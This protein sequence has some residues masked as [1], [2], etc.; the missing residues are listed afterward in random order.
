M[1]FGTEVI[2][3]NDFVRLTLEEDEV[4][5]N[6]SLEMEFFRI[7]T[8]YRL[9]NNQIQFTGDL[10]VRKYEG[11][12]IIKELGMSEDDER[13]QRMLTIGS[14]KYI[15]KNFSQEE[16]TVDMEDL[17]GRFYIDWEELTEPMNLTEETEEK[18]SK[19][20]DDYSVVQEK[21]LENYDNYDDESDS[22]MSDI[23]SLSTITDLN[24][25]FINSIDDESSKSLN[26]MDNNEFMI[27]QN[28]LQ[29]RIY[30]REQHGTIFPALHS[31]QSQ[32]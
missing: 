24:Q 14:Y 6:K 3:T 19:N 16:Y 27:H 4:S 2:R 31:E 12:N 26:D 25:S 22:Q 5:S 9:K 23:E 21:K 11:D 13:L 32:V 7:V 8:M 1:V 17:A 20:I 10:Y 18:F 28:S 29:L 30:D 15:P